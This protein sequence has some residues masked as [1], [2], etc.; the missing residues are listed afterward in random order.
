[1]GYTNRGDTRFRPVP[2]I[3][4]YMLSQNGWFLG[5]F[6]DDTYIL[7]TDCKQNYVCSHKAVAAK[8][9]SN[10]DVVRGL[11]RE[12]QRREDSGHLLLSQAQAP[13]G[14][15]YIEWME[16]PLRH[17]CKMSRCNSYT[18]Y[19]SVN[20]AII[21]ITPSLDDM[22]Q[23]QTVIRCFSYAETVSLYKMPTYSHYK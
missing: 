18:Q 13:W 7:A 17:S 14:S 8:S 2:H 15:S 21:V 16:H 6:A 1:M 12:N 4:Q 11:E 5:L 19:N 9:Q 22:F 23:P 10:W 3:L 20:N